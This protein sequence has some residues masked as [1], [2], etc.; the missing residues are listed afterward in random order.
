MA[1]ADTRTPPLRRRRPEPGPAPVVSSRGR[2]LIRS[3]LLFIA[4]VLV[5]DALIGER[6]F[7]QTLRAGREYAEAAA[8]LDRLRQENGRLRE[9]A[10]RLREDPGAIEAVARRELGL[11]RP[12]EVLVIVK[13]IDKKP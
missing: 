12:G 7:V 8:T 5:V 11:I 2:R 13:D 3:L 1:D 6:G 10:R 9:E 4:C